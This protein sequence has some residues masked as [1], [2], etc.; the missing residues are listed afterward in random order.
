MIVRWDYVNE[1]V[2]VAQ[3]KNIKTASQV[4]G[5]DH[6]NLTKHLTNLEEQLGTRLFER[7]DTDRAKRTVLTPVGKRLYLH[8]KKFSEFMQTIRAGTGRE[9]KK[10]K[11]VIIRTTPGLANS[12][13][14]NAICEITNEISTTEFNIETT[15]DFSNPPKDRIFIAG[16][17][18]LGG[19]FS[20]ELMVTTRSNLYVSSEYAKHIELPRNFE[21]CQYHKFLVLDNKGAGQSEYANCLGPK[22]RPF[23]TSN[24]L[25]VLIELC[26]KGKGILEL[27]DLHPATY[28]LERIPLESEFPMVNIFLYHSNE[29]L[30]D[31]ET[32]NLITKL[33]EVIANIKLKWKNS[34]S[35]E[36]RF[37][38]LSDIDQDT[39]YEPS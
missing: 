33:K 21:E 38:S 6:S 7:S 31:P 18:D 30:S 34:C 9:G 27:A 37:N 11:T 26:R 28:S 35:Q 20:K 25:E 2:A 10:L 17:M 36:N 14:L 1:F 23:I 15:Y 12:I 13:L 8:A 22:I 5:L 16:D 39:W 32:S 19:G 29:Q 3:S 24:S 4:V